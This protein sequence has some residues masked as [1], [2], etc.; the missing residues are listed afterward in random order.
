MKNFKQLQRD[1][2]F[3]DIFSKMIVII[4]AISFI[5]SLCWTSFYFYG[6]GVDLLKAPLSISDFALAFRAW[7]PWLVALIGAILVGTTFSIVVNLLFIFIAKFIGEKYPWFKKLCTEDIKNSYLIIILIC[8]ILIGISYFAYKKGVS[9]KSLSDKCEVI[10]L[11]TPQETFIGTV[12]A[13]EKGLLIKDIRMSETVF[14][15]NEQIKKI[16][17]K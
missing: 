3:L 13:L 1:Q 2:I 4:P 5:L 7:G 6:L 12:I 15:Y 17:Y 9:D 16:I 8:T 11:Y 10:S 14:L